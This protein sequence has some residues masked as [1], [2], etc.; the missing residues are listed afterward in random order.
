MRQLPTTGVTDFGGAPMT[1]V[2]KSIQQPELTY[3]T[4]VSGTHR[5]LEG[6]RAAGVHALVFAST[7]AVTG[8]MEDPTIT[9]RARLHPL[10]PYGATKAAAEMLLSAYTNCYGISGAALRFSN[11]YGP[12][13]EATDSFIPRLMRAARG[14]EGVQR[15][16]P[17]GEPRGDERQRQHRKQRAVFVAEQSR[18]ERRWPGGRR[19]RQQRCAVSGAQ[20]PVVGDERRAKLVVR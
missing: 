17:G 14:G 4:N 12:G 11:V 1:S 10:T 8:P 15:H 20:R 9:E 13:M 16:D 6:A 2:L 7:N 19:R 5:V 18:F 3:Q